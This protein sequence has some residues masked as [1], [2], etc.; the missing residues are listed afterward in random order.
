MKS[1]TPALKRD[2]K[3]H[4]SISVGLVQIDWICEI[5]CSLNTKIHTHNPTNSESIFL[6][7]CLHSILI[8][9]IGVNSLVYFPQ[10]STKIQSKSH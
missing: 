8:C 9:I 7:K 10:T 4:M 5:F 3:T 1:F 2:T 6:F